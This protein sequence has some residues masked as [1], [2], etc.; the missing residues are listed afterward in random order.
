MST[1]ANLL[2][3][4][5][6]TVAVASPRMGRGPRCK[7]HY[8]VGPGHKQS[9]PLQGSSHRDGYCGGQFSTLHTSVV[10]FMQ[11]RVRVATT[12]CLQEL[13]SH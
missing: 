8:V 13:D 4:S 10:H 12:K 3:N 7:L 1:I 6:W 2:A 11:R 5:Q 9:Q